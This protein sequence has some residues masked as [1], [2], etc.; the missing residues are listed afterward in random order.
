MNNLEPDTYGEKDRRETTIQ[1]Q[2]S[3]R[4]DQDSS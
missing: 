4:D 3:M 2:P 1:E